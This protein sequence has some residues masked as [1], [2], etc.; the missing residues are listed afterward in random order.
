[1]VDRVAPS[2]T[3]EDHTTEDQGPALMKKIKD[4]KHRLIV[5]IIAFLTGSALVVLTLSG[6]GAD[7]SDC[8]GDPGTVSARE[9]DSDT[10]STGTGKN[11]T[12]T[13]TT[14][15]ELTITR[16]D[17]TSYEKEVSS[18]AYDWYKTGSQFPSVKHCTDGKVKG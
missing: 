3:T 13:T 12:T 16:E 17:G 14:D 9:K 11:K 6:C 18:T 8:Q 2:T 15:Y 5:R 4:L 7:D 1:M 10:T